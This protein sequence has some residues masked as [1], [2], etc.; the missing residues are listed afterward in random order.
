VGSAEGVFYAAEAPETA[1]AEK[2]FYALLFF[3]ESP[4][5]PWPAN[6]GEYTAFAAEFAAAR[7]ID[8]TRKP[9]AAERN[10]WTD[11]TNYTECLALADAARA[12]GL[13]AIRYESVRDP[14][15]R[16]NL[17]LLTCRIFTAD[18]AVGRETWHLHFGNAGVRAVCESP[19]RTLRFDPNAFAADPR[20]AAMR[21][22]R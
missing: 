5:T 19:A 4:E 21:W 20:I 16:A 7:A 2:A 10:R 11:A 15:K 17:T 13:E 8:L 14:E 3:L 1:V 18:D 6:P 22:V 12:A 9:F